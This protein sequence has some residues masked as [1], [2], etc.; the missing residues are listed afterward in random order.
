[1]TA[2][3]HERALLLMET[4]GGTNVSQENRKRR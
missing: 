4:N 2:L 1:M 3:E